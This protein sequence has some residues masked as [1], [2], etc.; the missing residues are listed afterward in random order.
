VSRLALAAIFLEFGIVLVV[1]PWSRYWDRNYFSESRPQLH[2]IATNNF[3]RGAV[4]GL[5][6]VNVG[7]AIVELGT[8][9]FVRRAPSPLSVF[10]SSGEDS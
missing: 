1:V 5:G 2:V 4:S 7:V 10:G 6:L 9:L 8:L 3:V